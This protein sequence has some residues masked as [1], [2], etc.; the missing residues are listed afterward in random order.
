MFRLYWLTI[1]DGRPVW[2]ASTPSQIPLLSLLRKHIR[3]SLCEEHFWIRI[4]EVFCLL[5]LTLQKRFGPIGHLVSIYH[6]KEGEVDLDRNR[7]SDLYK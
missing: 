1:F 7:R 6:F 4:Q 5:V 3:A 2:V